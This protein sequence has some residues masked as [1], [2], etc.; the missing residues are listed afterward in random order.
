MKLNKTTLVF[1]FAV[2][3]LL[4]AISGCATQEV[5]PS[6]PQLDSVTLQLQWVTQAQF[7]GYY[8][9]LDKG[10]YEEE[11]IDIT[12][13]PGGPDIL[14]VDSIV[15]GTADFGT[16]LLADVIVAIQKGTPLVSIGQIQQSN[17]LLLIAKATSGISEPQDFLG[18][19]VGVWL[20]SWQAQ[21][22]ALVAKEGIKPEDFTLVSQGFSM[23]SFLNDELDVASAMIYNEYHVVLESGMSP[24]EINI[25]DYA[26]YGLDFPGDVLMTSKR[27]TEENPDLVTRMVR[28]SIRGWQY[29][30][31]NPEETVDIVLK[32][33]KPGIQT[34]EHQLSM[35]NEITKLVQVTVRPIGFSDRADVR[36]T[37]DT[38][39]SYGIIE[40][41][42]EPE[43]VFTN[44]FWE[45]AN[46]E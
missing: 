40:E 9:A 13:K 30:V 12:I 19:Q 18:K 26:D 3:F 41:T 25:I 17:G 28:A 37:I 34:R 35:M 42:L 45:K 22:D 6:E 29:A 23:D 31:E 46:T 8:V 44:E 1:I 15:S 20:G 38:L 5:V 2:I 10:F 33:D 7:A 32:Y 39:F 21:F 24:D 14:P 16:G 36:R 27:L 4:A 43:Q 11:G